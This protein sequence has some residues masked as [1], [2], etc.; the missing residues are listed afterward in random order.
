VIDPTAG[1]TVTLDAAVTKPFAL[2]VIWE[3][4]VAEPNDPTLL[5]TVASVSTV[6]PVAS[7]VWL[8]LLTN[9]E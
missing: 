9:P 3:V 5:L 6:E 7:P 4:C 1:V 8:A 2:T